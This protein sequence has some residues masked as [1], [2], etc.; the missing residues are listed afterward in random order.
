MP[1]GLDLYEVAGRAQEPLVY[2]GGEQIHTL[3]DLSVAIS[4]ELGELA[5]ITH[6]M[7]DGVGI[8]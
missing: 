7:T 8:K 4:S 2:H 1:M 6:G 5:V 3:N